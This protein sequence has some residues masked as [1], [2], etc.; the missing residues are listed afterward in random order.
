MYNLLSGLVLI[1]C[2]H[3]LRG[4]MIHF[5]FFYNISFSKHIVFADEVFVT[6]S[7]A[8]PSIILDHSSTSERDRCYTKA[9]LIIF[10]DDCVALIFMVLIVN[11]VSES[12]TS[13]AP[14]LYVVISEGLGT[15]AELW[16]LFLVW[17]SGFILAFAYQAV[18]KEPYAECESLDVLIFI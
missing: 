18:E 7:S 11:T 6:A 8:F 16:L 4:S 10:S 12:P 1:L 3:S 5:F 2:Y 9:M 15:H 13:S 14:H 17:C